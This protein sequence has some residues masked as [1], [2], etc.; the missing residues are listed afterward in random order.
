MPNK[1]FAIR[2]NTTDTLV[3][4]FFTEEYLTV[5][6]L[7]NTMAEEV[8]FSSFTVDKGGNLIKSLSRNHTI[9]VEAAL[10]L[11][12]ELL[13]TAGDSLKLIRI[14]S[15]KSELAKVG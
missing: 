13:K 10:E 5:N 1:I 15:Q 6:L 4:V 14:N 7:N 8:G 12:N 9:N 3:H 2:Y 11:Y